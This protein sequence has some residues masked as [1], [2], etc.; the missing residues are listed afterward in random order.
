MSGLKTFLVE[1]ER[2]P[3]IY[4]PGERVAGKLHV[5]TDE[6]IMINKIMIELKGEAVVRWYKILPL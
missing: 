6:N 2:T 5:L 3:A 4:S 1:L